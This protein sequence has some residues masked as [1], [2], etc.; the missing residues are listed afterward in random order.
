MPPDVAASG[1]GRGFT[2]RW[3]LRED[4]SEYRGTI[5][6]IAAVYT[7]A[8]VFEFGHR[9]YQEDASVSSVTF[10][11]ALEDVLNRPASGDSSE[12]PLYA[13]RAR[14]NVAVHT[15]ELP[16]ADLAAGILGPSVAAAKS[17][18]NH[19]GFTY[20]SRSFIENKTQEFLSGKI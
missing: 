7:V 20:V 13:V 9:L 5:H 16:R 1:P 4:G 18:F 3:R 8:E 17:L 6:L 14:R 15:A 19:I 12:D 11:I 10:R 2:H